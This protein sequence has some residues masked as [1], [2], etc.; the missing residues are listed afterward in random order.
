MKTA[1]CNHLFRALS[2]DKT[3]TSFRKQPFYNKPPAMKS[4]LFFLSLIMISLASPQLSYAGQAPAPTTTEVSRPM[5]PKEAKRQAR[6]QKRLQKVKQIAERRQRLG[7]KKALPRYI[8][9]ALLLVA[10]AIGF[11]LLSGAF[12]GI[13]GGFLSSLFA[14]LGALSALGAV[15][16]LVLWLI[17]NA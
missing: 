5:T 2:L 1:F 8:L 7:K 10:A 4:L 11:G 13:L 6:L 15:V 14:V 16:F 9:Y 12:S 3:E 17:E